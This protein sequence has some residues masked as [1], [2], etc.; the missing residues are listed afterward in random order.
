MIDTNGVITWT[1][2]L[3]QAGTTNVFTTI[4][5]NYDVYAPVNQSLSATDSFTVIVNPLYEMGMALGPSPPTGR[6]CTCA[7]TTPATPITCWR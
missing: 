7:P 1:P 4:V 3:A 5:T 6:T 2:T